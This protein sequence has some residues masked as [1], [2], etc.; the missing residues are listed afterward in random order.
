LV[1]GESLLGSVV[2]AVERT[3][4]GKREAVEFLLLLS[5]GEKVESVLEECWELWVL[6]VYFEVEEGGVK[7]G[8]CESEGIVLLGLEVVCLL[9][10]ALGFGK[11]G[12]CAV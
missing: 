7:G 4:C 1:E 6:W 10:K 2:S 8:E 5:F 9:E 11:A 3:P 12:L